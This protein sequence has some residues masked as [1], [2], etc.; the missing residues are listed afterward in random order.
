MTWINLKK[1]LA[2]KRTFTKNI[3]YDW[4]YW[5]VNYLS[6]LIEKTVGVV[7]DQIKYLF[8][9]KDYSKPKRVKT[10]CGGEKKQSEE[11]I[12]LSIFL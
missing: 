8:K 10:V 2:E 12:N 1:K 11:N 4:Y 7:K 6:E 9:T 5:L 3:W